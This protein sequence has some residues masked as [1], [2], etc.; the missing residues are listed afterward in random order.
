MDGIEDRVVPINQVRRISDAMK[1]AGKEFEHYEFE[2]GN[3]NLS[4]DVNR[5]AAFEYIDAFLSKHLSDQV[6]ASD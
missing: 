2:G 6:I 1:K 5:I 4:Y 3:H